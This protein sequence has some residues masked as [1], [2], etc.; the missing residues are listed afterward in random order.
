MA[1]NNRNI[2]KEIDTKLNDPVLRGALARFAEQYPVAR[3]KAYENVED[4]DGLRNSFKAMKVDV[5]EHLEEIADKFEASVK[6]RGA[7]FYRAKDGAALKEYLNK[8]CKEN[9][10]KRIIKSKSMATE[11]IHL[12]EYLKEEGYHIMETDMGEW[13]ISIAGHKPSHMVMPAIH[14]SKE[15]CAEYFSKELGRKIEP[16]IY[17]MIQTARKNLRANSSKLTWVLRVLTSVSPKTVLSVL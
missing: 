6:A 15:Q 8:V 7:H 10:V 13:I 14:L 1:E 4:V 3:L 16:V 5:V 12:N 9:N 17:D 2:R 11:E